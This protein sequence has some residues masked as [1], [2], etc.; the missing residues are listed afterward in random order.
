MEKNWE[1]LDSNIGKR[2][3]IKW[4]SGKYYPGT[5]TNFQNGK[6]EVH[7]DDGDVRWYY[8]N[9]MVMRLINDEDEYVMIKNK[10]RSGLSD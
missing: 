2:I 1:I 6:H 8:L 4:S 5:I 3:E 7:Y 9:E 10:D